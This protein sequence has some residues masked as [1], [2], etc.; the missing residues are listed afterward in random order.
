VACCGQVGR[1]E[2]DLGIDLDVSCLFHLFFSSFLS[3]MEFW[4]FVCLSLGWTRRKD[5]IYSIVE[6]WVMCRE[7]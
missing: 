3:F 1:L 7:V 2:F 4:L 6:W 5:F